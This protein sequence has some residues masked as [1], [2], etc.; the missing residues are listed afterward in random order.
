M[1]AIR[2]SH[3]SRCSLHGST[4]GG[5]CT[6]GTSSGM[7]SRSE[8]A[9]GSGNPKAE[10]QLSS[11]SGGVMRC[12]LSTG[13]STG[14][15]KLLVSWAPSSYRFAFQDLQQ[16]VYIHLAGVIAGVSPYQQCRWFRRWHSSECSGWNLTVESA[17][18]GLIWSIWTAR[19]NQASGSLSD[20]LPMGMPASAIEIRR[21]NPQR[22]L[23][24]MVFGSEY[25]ASHTRSRN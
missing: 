17:I 3:F 13:D 4:A 25:S 1:G 12:R 14:R 6:L 15:T 23:T 7:S 16:L 18:S 11:G 8:A 9:P 24:T 10:N 2:L 5:S 21:F 20:G 22:N 19:Q